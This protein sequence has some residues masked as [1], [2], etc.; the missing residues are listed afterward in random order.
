M[1]ISWPF[2]SLSYVTHSDVSK[3]CLY[4]VDGGAYRKVVRIRILWET[5]SLRHRTLTP[6]MTQHIF[7]FYYFKFPFFAV[8]Y[9]VHHHHFLVYFRSCFHYFI[10]ITIFSSFTFLKLKIFS[11]SIFLLCKSTIKRLI[12]TKNK[13]EKKNCLKQ[14]GTKK[15]TQLCKN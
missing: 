1:W 5:D 4:S 11:F 3:K 9:N 10:K 15:Q 14:I 2:C 8:V 7:V 6:L 13:I 12:E